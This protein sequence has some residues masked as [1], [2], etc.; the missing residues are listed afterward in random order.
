MR[1]LKRILPVL[2][3]TIVAAGAFI[4]VSNLQNIMDWWRLRSYVPSDII[5]KI[6]TD[7][8]M[9]D[10]GRRLFY[11]HDPAIL[12]KAEFQNGCTVGEVSIVLGCYI[13]NQRIYL[14]D[15]QEE[16]LSGVE[17]VTAA[18]EM[19][20]A[21]YDR[22]KPSEKERVDRLL[23]EAYERV[24]DAR[25]IENINTYRQRDPSVVPNELHSILGTEVRD[26]P[27]E[28]EEY[29]K[30][31]FVDRLGVVTLAESYAEEFEVREKQIEAYDSQLTNING[32]ITRMQ[33]DLTVENEALEQERALID[34]LRG[35]V[36]AY[37]DAV[38]SF[39]AKV[40]SYNASAKELKSL[41]ETYNSII[42][43]RNAIAVEER[44]LVEAIDTRATEL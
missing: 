17:E 19:L 28:L 32:E 9:N 37:N 24:T 5:A 23:Q 35:D 39:N 16:R 8:R 11:I 42:E 1:K 30:A 13:S 20:H 18:H 44:E 38:V 14:F 34:R 40:G 4:A 10:E 21:A 7:A 22:L 25:I 15:V 12:S 6:A 29:Y 43:Q 3:L 26:L 2:T 31:Y 36:A 41:I 33:A 27:A